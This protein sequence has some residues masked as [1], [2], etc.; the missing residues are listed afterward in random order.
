MSKGGKYN[1][2]LTACYLAFITQAITANLAPLLFLRFHTQFGISLGKIALI[3][4]AFFITQLTVDL[5]CAGFINKIGYRLGALISEALAGVGLVGLSFLPFILP[6]PFV[7]ILASAILYAIG[8][9]LIEVLA[10]PIVEACPFDNKASV[11]SILHSFYCWGRPVASIYPAR[12]CVANMN[13]TI[14]IFFLRIIYCNL[15]A[16]RLF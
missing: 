5:I 13:V 16:P 15:P 7:G 14:Y 6:D 8:S 12:G 2:T 10:S 11:M 4:I 1:R 3:P 9:G